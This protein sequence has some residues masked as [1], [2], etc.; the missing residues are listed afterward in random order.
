MGASTKM[1][2]KLFSGDYFLHPDYPR[3]SKK[4][5]FTNSDFLWHPHCRA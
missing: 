1:E 3:S 4:E 2:F 5:S